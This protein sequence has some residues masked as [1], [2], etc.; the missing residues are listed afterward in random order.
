VRPPQWPFVASLIV[1]AACS[2]DYKI[3]ATAARVVVSPG[4]VDVGVVPMGGSASGEITI[5]SVAG[6]NVAVVAAELLVVEGDGFSVGA[7]PEVPE[8]GAASLAIS[9]A[10]SAVGY[11]LARLTLTTDEPRN[12]LHVIDLRGAAGI[13]AAEVWPSVLDFGPVGA[14]TTADLPFTFANTGDLDL[15]VGS[16]ILEGGG[17]FTL[18][19]AT[20][21]HVVAGDTA[22]FVVT[23]SPIDDT[24]A[25]A[26]LSFLLDAAS[27]VLTLRGND[28]TNGTAARYDTDGDGY[29]T[30]APDCDD[31]RADVHPGA[32]ETCDGADQDCDGRVDEGTSCTDDDGD[33]VTEDDGDCNDGDAAVFP[34]AT[35]ALGN[36]VD[37]DCDGVIDRGTE[38]TDGDG[39]AVE[40]G[41]CAPADATVYPGAP[42][43]EDGL[44]NDCDGRTDEG[45]TRYDDDGDGMTEAGGDCDD[46]DA[47]VYAGARE[48]ADGAD[49]DCDGTVD[50]GTTFGDDDDDGWTETGGDC[51]D[52]DAAV[53]PGAEEVDGDGTDNDCDGTV[54]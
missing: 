42:E 46:T 23:F 2:P 48:T 3:D 20:P 5:T 44:D 38:D 14:G 8:D 19:T 51:D 34:D 49:D 21:L 29:T 54:E 47:T 35:E 45:T 39:Y 27:P 17:P 4:L 37:D 18:A 22:A 25:A 36:G 40:G 52:A 43:L 26:A 12:N 16:G 1:L 31:A 53:H 33:G 30:C 50:E 32:A 10:P 13:A 11:H 9:F 24:P 7:L 28:C 15:T 41:D 6:G